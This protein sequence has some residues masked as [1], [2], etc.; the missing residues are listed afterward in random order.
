MP[1]ES[2]RLRQEHAQIA[3]D[4][5]YELGSVRLAAEYLSVSESTIRRRLKWAARYGYTI[6]GDDATQG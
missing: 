5:V 3:L 6:G 4:A 1:P 2:E